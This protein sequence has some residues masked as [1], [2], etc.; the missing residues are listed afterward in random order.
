MNRRV[1]GVDFSGA[2]DA[3][4][5]LWVAVG[6]R[7][8]AGL[9]IEACWRG[10]QL[11]GSS[12][13]RR[14]CLDALCQFIATQTAA[15]VGLDFPFGLPLS[16]SA[17]QDWEA[18]VAGFAKRY[19][20]PERFRTW[21][22]ARTDGRE[23]KRLTDRLSRTPFSPYNL[24]LYRQTFYGISQVLAP[25]VCGQ[26]VCVLPMQ[27]ARAGRPW[28]I[29]IC[30]ASTLR[31][32]CWTQPY[33]GRG[34]RHRN[35]RG[36]IVQGLEARGV[37]FAHEDLRQ[38]VLTDPGGD[39][40]DSVLAAWAAARA[41]PTRV[42][43]QLLQASRQTDGHTAADVLPSRQTGPAVGPSAPP[44][45]PVQCGWAALREGWVFV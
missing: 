29:E 43:A 42:R 17:E 11:P 10:D 44:V 32:E 18:F 23:L 31:A 40:L 3:G 14:F 20:S 6:S 38:R 12:V 33:K 5:R 41:Q 34:L 36:R 39:A 19:R 4:R 7:T 15:V 21:C 30:P 25:L 24:R 37:Q 26:R 16:L 22:L 35:G 28:V 2:A 9:R 8:Q 13:S 1:L 45:D 27:P